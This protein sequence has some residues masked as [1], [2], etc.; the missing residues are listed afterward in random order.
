[1]DMK[2]HPPHE[3]KQNPSGLRNHPVIKGFRT[4]ISNLNQSASMF[5]NCL[6]RSWKRND[7]TISNSIYQNNNQQERQRALK[8]LDISSSL[9]SMMKYLVIIRHPIRVAISNAHFTSINGIATFEHVQLF[10]KEHLPTIT[11]WQVQSLTIY[12]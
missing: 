7:I 1:M 6:P 8:T 10:V 5:I 9:S 4:C 11:S 3:G 2:H 12:I